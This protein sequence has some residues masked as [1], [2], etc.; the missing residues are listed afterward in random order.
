MAKDREMK[1][2]K[3]NEMIE[4]D[5][6]SSNEETNETLKKNE[7][8]NKRQEKQMEKIN[9]QRSMITRSLSKLVGS[10]DLS[11]KTKRELKKLESS[12]NKPFN[13][14]N[15]ES[16]NINLE[17]E[18]TLAHSE[19]GIIMTN[20]GEP[21]NFHDAWFHPDMETRKDGEKL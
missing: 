12:F 1:T 16:V 20:D 2:A 10:N 8:K 14:S 9:K 11:E 4:E 3:E 7:L 18:V 15:D 19:M 21:N 6:K 17:H 5:D 13:F